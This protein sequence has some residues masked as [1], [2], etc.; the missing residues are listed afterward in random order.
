MQRT[1]TDGYN[2]QILTLN[3]DGSYRV[4]TIVTVTKRIRSKKDEVT[5]LNEYGLTPN[6]AVLRE[7]GVNTVTYE[8]DDDLVKQYGKIIKRNDEKVEE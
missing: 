8:F 5:V 6:T 3:D 4:E 2:Y 1:F 7:I